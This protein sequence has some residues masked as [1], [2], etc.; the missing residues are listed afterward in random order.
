MVVGT[1]TALGVTQLFKKCLALVKAQRVPDG[2]ARSTKRWRSAP[3]STVG[4]NRKVDAVDT[5]VP[6][7]KGH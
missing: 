6:Q 7:T 4:C 1:A 5:A 3:S 2:Q